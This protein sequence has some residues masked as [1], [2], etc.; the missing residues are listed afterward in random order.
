MGR[1]LEGS[2]NS[3]KQMW[4]QGELLHIG[5]AANSKRG[6][7]HL[8]TNYLRLRN[9]VMW[10]VIFLHLCNLFILVYDT[11]IDQPQYGHSATV[12]EIARGT[13]KTDSLLPLY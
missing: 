10:M 11:H 2:P 8:L 1:Q 3:S 13:F 6:K 7:K 12:Y 9:S 4:K 5:V